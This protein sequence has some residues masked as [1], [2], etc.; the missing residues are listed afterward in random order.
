MIFEDDYFEQE[1][2]NGYVIKRMMKRYW[3]AG[4]E[5]LLELNRVCELLGIVYYADYGTLLGAVRH[6]GFIPWDDDIDVSMTRGDFE[7]FRTRAPEY[8]KDG[9]MIYNNYK[10][11]L[12]PMRLINTIAPQIGA[13]F[14]AKY[15][16]CPY[17][18]GIDIY[19]LDKIPL[20][21]EDDEKF[22]MLHNCIK[23]LAQRHDTRFMSREEH[24]K[25]YTVDGRTEESIEELLATVENM[26]GAKIDRNGDMAPQLTTLL[27]AVQ[28]LYWDE[29]VNEIVYMH[30][31]CRK[32]RRPLPMEYYGE[33]VWLD[34]E[35]TQIM[36]PREYHKVLI[37]RFGEDYMVPKRE[38]YGH[39]D[40]AYA[41]SQK[42]LL[43]VFEKCGITPPEEYLE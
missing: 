10:T 28:A 17:T 3:A 4:Q 31:W 38:S 9:V 30:G 5:V 18:V 33:P 22:M 41:K 13:D 35:K 1:E 32:G 11:A 34:F 14:L 25:L 2:R 39:D 20:S 23:Y 21:R 27:N 12:A 19:V 37:E 24:E 42:T 36:C 29:N 15:H 40:I 8:L 16:G 6:K 43:E 26:T 7:I